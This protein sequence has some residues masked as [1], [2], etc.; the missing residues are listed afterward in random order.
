MVWNFVKEQENL[1]RR[2]WQ[3]PKQA[4]PCRAAILELPALL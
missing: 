2:K 3:Y 1:R 4:L